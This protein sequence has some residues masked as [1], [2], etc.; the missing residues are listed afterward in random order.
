M[1]ETITLK[2]GAVWLVCAI[3]TI[4]PA[5]ADTESNLSIPVAQVA[6]GE[7]REGFREQL[8]VSS[9]IILGLALGSSTGVGSLEQLIVNKSGMPE[10]KTFCLRAMSVDGLFWAENS[11]SH[12]ASADFVRTEPVSIKHESELANYGVENILV[13]AGFSEGDTAVSCGD[14][15]LI[16]APVV[17]DANKTYDQLTVFINSE[18]RPTDLQLHTNSSGESNSAPISGTCS[19]AT[20][21]TAAIY[22]KICT[23]MLTDIEATGL[24]ELIFMFS[25]GPFGAE[26]WIEKII[27]PTRTRPINP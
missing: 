16:Y 23:V 22:D 8:S 24:A 20:V 12:T 5:I 14:G 7:F 10:A 15:S 3:F 13:T 26:P 11:Y 27:L 4:T 6:D 17:D 2:I 25:A 1:K 21:T 19:K 18:S 9:S